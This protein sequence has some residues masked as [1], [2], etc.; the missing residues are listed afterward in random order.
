MNSHYPRT[1]TPIADEAVQAVGVGSVIDLGQRGG[2]LRVL[3]GRVWV[4]SAG[5]ADDH[6]LQ[7]GESLRVPA[8]RTLVETWG[9]TQPA[10]IAWQAGSLGEQ[11][12]AAVRHAGGSAAARLLQNVV[13]AAV[14]SAGRLADGGWTRERA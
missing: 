10:L 1:P 5:D 9:P 13:P 7:A 11:L 2:R 14:R 6:V 8:A 4:T 12:A 3:A